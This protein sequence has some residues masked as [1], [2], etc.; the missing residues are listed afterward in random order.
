VNK[1]PWVA[2]LSVDAIVRMKSGV[3]SMRGHRIQSPPA[4]IPN[5]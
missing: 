3:A 4:R 2:F 1:N 5:K